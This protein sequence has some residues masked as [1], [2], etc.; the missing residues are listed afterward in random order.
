MSKDNRES[1]KEKKKFVKVDVEEGSAS[2][3]M[4]GLTDAVSG[5]AK[6]TIEGVRAAATIAGRTI[7][8]AT[9]GL[10]QGID[11]GANIP[12]KMGKGV[13][14]SVAGGVQGTVKGIKKASERFGDAVSDVGEG[15]SKT[16][17]GIKN[18]GEDVADLTGVE[19]K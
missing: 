10:K 19:K 14:G 13:A 15:I 1:E 6:A 8:G 4:D 3:I 16:G 12:E 2:K 7:D 18:A 9:Q 5:V 11:Q 17:Q